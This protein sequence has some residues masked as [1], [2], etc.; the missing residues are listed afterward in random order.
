MQHH[1]AQSSTFNSGN[2]RHKLRN[3]EAFSDNAGMLQI[4]RY[5][6]NLYLLRAGPEQI[7]P[8]VSIL[9]L[10]LVTA[11]VLNVLSLVISNTSTSLGFLTIVGVVAFRQMLTLLLF[12]A[13]AIFKNVPVRTVPALIALFGTDIFTQ[14]FRLSL[15]LLQISTEHELISS[16]IN[17]LYLV[18]VV[19]SLIVFGFIVNRAFNLGLMLGIFTGFTFSLVT[20]YMSQYIFLPA[21]A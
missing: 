10:L 7:P 12:A 5:F 14:L 8:R 2:C 17:H 21:A 9:M 1:R 16:L 19:W 13:L 3:P 20:I 18:F 4:T 6:W 11:S 15:D